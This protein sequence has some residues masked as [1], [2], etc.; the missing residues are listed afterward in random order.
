MASSLPAVLRAQQVLLLLPIQQ[1]ARP[2]PPPPARARVSAPWQAG[3][4]CWAAPTHATCTA[5]AAARHQ[6]AQAATCS[7]RTA[8][9]LAV[10]CRAPWLPMR[11]RTCPAWHPP[12]R[13]RPYA[14]R[15]AS[16]RSCGM[17]CL[18]LHARHQ[19]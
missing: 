9:R 6:A 12:A 1:L 10:A 15:A 19:Q 5:P 13:W 16:L 7:A 8:G 3:C 14:P 4:C 17:W 2:L 11:W 18:A